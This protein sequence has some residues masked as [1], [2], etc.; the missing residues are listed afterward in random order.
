[1]NTASGTLYSPNERNINLASRT[2]KGDYIYRGREI[3]RDGDEWAVEDDH[4]KIKYFPS[5]P[6]ARKAID[7]VLDKK[8]KTNK[9]SKY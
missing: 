6:V 5:V 1:M 3:L 4:G 9:S 2:T 8:W 7:R